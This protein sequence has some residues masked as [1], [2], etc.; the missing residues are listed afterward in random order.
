MDNE[1]LQKLNEAARKAVGIARIKTPKEKR[2]AAA[3]RNRVRLQVLKDITE[4]EQATRNAPELQ[5]YKG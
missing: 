5:C 2:L 3:E 4:G 1:T